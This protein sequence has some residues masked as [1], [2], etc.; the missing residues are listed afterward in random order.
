VDRLGK[1][2]FSLVL[3]AVAGM[4]AAQPREIIT[5]LHP[6]ITGSPVMATDSAGNVVWKERYA[7]YGERRVKAD[8]GRNSLWF[9]GKDQD[10][11]TGLSYFGARWY[12]PLIGRFTGVDPVSFVESSPQSFNRYAYANNNPYKFKDPNGEWVVPVIVGLALWVGTEA[13]LPE[14]S[15]PPGSGLVQQTTLPDASGLLKATAAVG[16]AVKM[17]GKTADDAARGVTAFQVD[18][19][20]NLQ[21]ASQVGDDLALHHAG[22]KHAMQQVIPD[23]NPQAAP[24]IAL[25]T[26]QHRAIPNLTGTYSGSA[27]DL[28]AR[29]IRNLRNHTDAPN[30]SLRELIRLNKEA[31]PDA[32]VR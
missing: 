22:Q 10:P 31:Y 6:D 16:A 29:D 30:N 17:L 7:P 14:P 9:T 25:P 21:R 2:L 18:R 28:L 19:F 20:D 26:V 23:Y 32:F 13:F 3:L 4:T 15:V 1:I 12:D 8:D 27:R 11:T 5:Y 24:T